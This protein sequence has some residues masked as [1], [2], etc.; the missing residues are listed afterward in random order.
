MSDKSIYG[1]AAYVDINAILKGLRDE[2][3]L[4]DQ[5]IITIER[6][7][8]RKSQQ[9]AI[10]GRV[11]AV[12]KQVAAESSRVGNKKAAKPAMPKEE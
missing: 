7:A 1:Y 8:V 5:A 6:Y 11:T 10:H 3:E 9:P 4:I 2:R 12:A